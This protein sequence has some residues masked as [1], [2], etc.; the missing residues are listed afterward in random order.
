[1]NIDK[2]LALARRASTS[3]D[4]PENPTERWYLRVRAGRTRRD[5]MKAAENV[6]ISQDDLEGQVADLFRTVE[7]LLEENPAVYVELMAPGAV[8]PTES[9][10]FA[11]RPGAVVAPGAG[12]QR[13]L[14]AGIADVLRANTEV[15]DRLLSHHTELTQQAAALVRE[16]AEGQAMSAVLQ[17]YV[18][19]LQNQDPLERTRLVIQ[20]VRDQLDALIPQEARLPLAL[21]AAQWLMNRVEESAKKNAP[22]DLAPPEPKG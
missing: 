15:I 9:L 14:E 2:L 16:N 6:V 13:S 1:M 4:D 12:R 21:A 18:Q 22:P 7:Y 3:Q 20:A 5:A 10:P 8:H 19:T 11:P 17:H